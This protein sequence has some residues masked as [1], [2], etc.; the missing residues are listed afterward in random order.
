[1]T[2]SGSDHLKH[3]ARTIAR[4]TGR[5]FPD[6]LAELRDSGS[7]PTAPRAASKELVRV[8][9]GLADPWGETG[10]CARPAGHHELDR[11]TWHS[12]CDADPHYPMHIWNGWFQAREAADRTEHESR[13]AA[14]SPAERDRYEQEQAQDYD[15]ELAAE[16]AAAYDPEEER[17]AEAVLDAAD[18]ERWAAEA[19]AHPDDVYDPDDEY[20]DE[21]GDAGYDYEER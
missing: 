10:R 17:H 15:S 16:M 18:E 3:R 11:I 12:Q 2:K 19:E 20:D 14:M 21:Y 13:Q 5:R 4:A 8:C 7:R 9:S 1:M 6:V